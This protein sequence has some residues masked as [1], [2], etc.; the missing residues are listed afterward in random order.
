MGSDEIE[1]MDETI[2]EIKEYEKTYFKLPDWYKGYL[3]AN[4][5]ILNEIC[6]EF[7]YRAM[8]ICSKLLRILNNKEWFIMAVPIWV[9][10]ECTNL[11]SDYLSFFK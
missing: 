4:R 3:L 9:H 7:V 8:L 2:V 11:L 5:L 1:K 10:I 6:P